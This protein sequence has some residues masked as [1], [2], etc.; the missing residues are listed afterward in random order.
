M[1]ETLPKNIL[2]NEKEKQV[3]KIEFNWDHT[4][5]QKRCTKEHENLHCIYDGLNLSFWAG[6][7]ATYILIP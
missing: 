5:F 2:M 7:Y 6:S 1:G 3:L 4:S